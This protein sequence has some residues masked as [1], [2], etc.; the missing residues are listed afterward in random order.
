MAS[1]GTGARIKGAQFERDI[2]KLLTEATGEDFLR[3]LGQTRG[4]GGEVPDVQPSGNTPLSNAIHI[5]CKRQKRCNIRGALD[6]AH[7]DIALRKLTPSPMPIVITKDDRED[8]LVT[9]RLQD[10][11][12]M[13]N[14]WIQAK[15]LNTK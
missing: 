15:G 12:E 2:S 9:L 6:Q 13:F 5:E 4:G 7:T 1:R 11:L 14:L 10:W 3:G 8:T